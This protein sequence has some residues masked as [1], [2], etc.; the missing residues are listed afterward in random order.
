MSSNNNDSSSDN[1]TISKI[2]SWTESYFKSKNIESPRLGA[3]LLLCSVLKCSRISLYTNFDKPL[4][5]NE[6]E[7]FKSFIKRRVDFEPVSYITNEKSFFDLDFYV[8]SN[9]LIPRPDTEKLIEVV[10]ELFSDRKEDKLKI[11]ELGTGSGIISVCLANYFKKAF[12][13]SVDISMDALRTAEFNAEKNNVL[14]NISFINSSWFSGIKEN[15][16]FDLIV[17]NPPYIKTSD[18]DLLQIEIKK[19]E[20]VLALDGGEDGLFCIHEIIKKADKFLKNNGF[21]IFEAGF[22]QKEEIEN[23]TSKNKNLSFIDMIKDYGNRD[24]VAVIKKFY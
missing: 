19:Y 4:L 14:S 24:R 13:A 23:L 8:N 16:F 12:F 3:E 17:S 2:L 22:D 5:K 10:I 20:P 18:I 9:V 6:L 11:L 7:I 21:L 15:N 1:W